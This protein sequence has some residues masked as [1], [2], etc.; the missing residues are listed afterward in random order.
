MLRMELALMPTIKVVLADDHAIIRAGIRSMLESLSEIELVGQ[1][2]NGR[3]ALALVEEQQPHVLLCDITMPEMNGLETTTRVVKD[4][5]NVRVIILSMHNSNEYVW[6]A[7]KA[8]AKGYLLKDAE[9]SELGFAIK[10]VASGM[11]YLTPAVSKKCIENYLQGEDTTVIVS[12][13]LT[14]RQREILQLIVEGHAL[15]QIAQ[16]LNLSVKTVET[17]R[18]M[19][20]DR[21]EIYD[22]PGLVRYA[23][24]I[25]MIS[26]ET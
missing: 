13:V 5:P 22:T 24:R 7:L 17:H 25:G 8:G 1:A 12:D 18:T 23:L 20:M 11:T 21:L 16:K 2:S 9:A 3:E 4:F 15:K 26:P 6:Q 10:T 19:L 14:P